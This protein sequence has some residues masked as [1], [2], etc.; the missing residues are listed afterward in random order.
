MIQDDSLVDRMGRLSVTQGSVYTITINGFNFV[1]NA[2]KL[3]YFHFSFIDKFAKAMIEKSC[4]E[5]KRQL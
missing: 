4:I 5:M 2:Y 3:S 1:M